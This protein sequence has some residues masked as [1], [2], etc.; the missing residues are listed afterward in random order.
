MTGIVSLSL[1]NEVRTSDELYFATL[2]T[3]IFAFITFLVVLDLSVLISEKRP[4]IG[5]AVM[6]VFN[7]HFV[8]FSGRRHGGGL[9]KKPPN[10]DFYLFCGYVS[11]FL[12]KRLKSPNS[13]QVFF[14]LLV[15]P[16]ASL[17]RSSR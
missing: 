1:L 16:A 13:A 8:P 2:F 9:R 12:I 4:A 5:T 3:T 17:L 11:V 14:I 7:C 10:C 15:L 6:L